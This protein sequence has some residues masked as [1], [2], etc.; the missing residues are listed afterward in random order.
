M[1]V[2]AAGCSYL[3]LIERNILKKVIGPIVIKRGMGGKIE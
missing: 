3:S 1:D 2:I